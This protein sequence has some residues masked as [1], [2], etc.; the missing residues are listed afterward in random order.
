MS[1][2]PLPIPPD[3]LLSGAARLALRY[4]GTFAPETLQQLLVD[5]YHQLAETAAVR[6]HLVVLAERLA[7]ERLA[8]GPPE[9]WTTSSPRSWPRSAR[10]SRSRRSPS[11]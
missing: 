3:R 4:G 7:D 6:T 9:S 1:T 10:T 2:T 11:R 5:S 8:H